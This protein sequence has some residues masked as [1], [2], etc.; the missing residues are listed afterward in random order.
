M[1]AIIT[2]KL[3]I[4]RAKQFVDSAAST[5]YYSFIGLPN[6]SDYSQTW[7]ISPFAPKD[8]FEQESDYWDTMIALKKVFSTDIRQAIRKIR[9]ESGVTYDMYRHDICRDVNKISKPSG[10]TSLYS[11]NYYVV[12]SNY[13][14]YICLN[15]GIT[16]EN[17]NGRPS[18]F[19]PTF[20]DLEPRIVG[21]GSDGYVWKYLYTLNA[22]DIIR[23]DSINFIPVPQN[24]GTDDQTFLIKNNAEV[25]GQL[26]MC[27]ITNRGDYSNVSGIRNRV[28]RN[29]PIKGDGSG[30]FATI[31]FNNNAQVENIFVTNGGENYTYGR[32]D[33]LAGGLPVPTVNPQFDVII[34]PKG[35]HGFDIYNELGAFYVSIYSRIEND[36]DNPDFI[37]GNEFSRVG[38][39]ENPLQF[40]STDALNVDKVSALNAI[41]LVG[42]NNQTD[43]QS[44][45]FI[46]DSF[47]TQ[48]VGLGLTAVGRVVSYDRNT[49][50]LKYWQDKT[51]AGFNT[52]GSQTSPT[53]GFNLEQFT[54]TPADGGSIVISGGSIDL[55]IDT[56]FGSITNP[57]I[58]TTINNRTYRLG[59]SFINGLAN[60]EV[61]K[62][63]GNIIYVDNRAAIT[64]SPNQK[65]DIKVILQF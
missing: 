65:E 52:E 21:T 61:Q 37:T 40:G 45:N 63:S 44:A 3:R 64:R 15:N 29:I 46:Q 14:V 25:S 60:P 9:W 47:I 55:N 30:A 5:N 12:N 20:T 42:I 31:T 11:S 16:P 57:G 17:P 62:H 48:T 53:F 56:T 22:S 54:S 51:L 43:Y 23:F 7:N 19:E 1:P 26:K 6:S 34:P 36:S 4:L 8:S 58:T 49:G 27:T 38:I 39:V 10:A 35:G 59:Q 28:F 2:D 33:V 24:W 18:Q 32:V 50:I 13:Q 41:K